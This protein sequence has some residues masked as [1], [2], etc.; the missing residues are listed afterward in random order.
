MAIVT[1]EV[2]NPT[3]A[4]ITTNGKTAVAHAITNLA[5]DNAALANGWNDL[6]VFLAGGCAVTSTTGSTFQQR[7]QQGFML[8]RLQ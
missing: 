6:V 7:E 2:A 5:F 4:D 8:E 1:L 3:G